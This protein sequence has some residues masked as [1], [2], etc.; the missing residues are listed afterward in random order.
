MKK[1]LLVVLLAAAGAA[2]ADSADTDDWRMF[3]RVLALVQPIV[4]AAASSSDPRAAEKE[5]DAIL[6]GRNEQANRMAAEFLDEAFQDMPPQYKG[7][8]A[9]IARDFAVLARRERERAAERGEAVA[10]ERALQARKDLQAMGLTYHDPA[11][12][13]GAVK[14]DDAIAVELYV[15]GRGVN[16][17][18]RDAEGRSALDLARRAGNAQIAELLSRNLP[19]AR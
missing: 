14:R 8:M 17:A 7:A 12:F 16:L 15:L 11:Q 1:L 3:A 9:S 10:P 2:R 4:H 6:A 19:A 5:V 13:L 18:A